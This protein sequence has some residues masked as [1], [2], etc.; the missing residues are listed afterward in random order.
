[1]QAEKEAKEK[2]ILL[3]SAANLVVA[4]LI[5]HQVEAEK[6]A[7]AEVAKAKEREL[8]VTRQLWT[9]VP[10]YSQAQADKA[11]AEKR[12]SKK[13]QDV[14]SSSRCFLAFNNIDRMRKRRPRSRRLQRNR[15]KRLRNNFRNCLSWLLDIVLQVK[16]A[17]SPKAAETNKEE[18][19]SN[20]RGWIALNLLQFAAGCCGRAGCCSSSEGQG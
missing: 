12:A 7:A 10:H 1:M 16:S 17:A 4:L 18:K 19:V 9:W 8:K 11:A 13:K 5:E 2:V 3:A 20:P 6:K 15:P 14:C